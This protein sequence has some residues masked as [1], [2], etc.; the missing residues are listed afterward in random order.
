[1]LNVS[2]ADIKE[3][4]DWPGLIE[5]LR[6]MFREGCEMPPRHHHRIKVAGDRDI[7]EKQRPVHSLFH[8]RFYNDGK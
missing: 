7:D 6:D 4:L 2:A 1:M 5:A 8:D 3:S